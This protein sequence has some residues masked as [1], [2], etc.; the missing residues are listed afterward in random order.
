MPNHEPKGAEWMREIASLGGKASARRKYHFPDPVTRC[1]NGL[2]AA[3]ARWGKPKWSEA[4]EAAYS[5]G[6][7]AGM[8]HG[9]GWRTRP[10]R[11]NLD[12]GAD[13]ES[14][15][16]GTNEINESSGSEVSEV[17]VSGD[18]DVSDPSDETLDRGFPINREDL[19]AALG[20]SESPKLQKFLSA[21]SGTRYR[22]W[23]IGTLA[24]KFGITPNE[25]STLWRDHNLSKGMATIIAGIPKIAADVVEDAQSVKVICP[26]CDGWGFVGVPEHLQENLGSK[27]IDCPNCEGA[28]MIRKP[29][30]DVD[31]KRMF[32][33]AGWARKGGGDGVQ[34]NVNAGQFPSVESV[35][36][37]M[38]RA[39]KS[40]KTID[41]RPE[42]M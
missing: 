9:T 22:G 11:S 30:S 28:G 32:D 18:G 10:N 15:I 7:K 31:R 20:A 42:D 26:H 40:A 13:A 12:A 25:L 27:M 5:I 1:L 4:E 6:Y 33:A 3:R 23:N 37:L 36:E 39:K 38:E 16:S 17:A 41:A 19:K 35:I 21:L 24:R 2:K 14:K 8:E 34:V 29:G